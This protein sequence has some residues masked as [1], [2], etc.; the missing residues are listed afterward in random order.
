MNVNRGNLFWLVIKV[1][2]QKTPIFP[3]LYEILTTDKTQFI[4][5]FA[6]NK[7]TMIP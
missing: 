2:I 4:L 5:K 3:V 7:L 6:S 1:D